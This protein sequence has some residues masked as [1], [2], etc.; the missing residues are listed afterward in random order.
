DRPGRTRTPRASRRARSVGCGPAHRRASAAT[1][2]PP[3]PEPARRRRRRRRSPGR[4]AGAD[5]A[6]SSGSRAQRNRRPCPTAPGYPPDIPEM[7]NT[8]TAGTGRSGPREPV[9]PIRP[10]TG[11]TVVERVRGGLSRGSPSDTVVGRRPDV[12]PRGRGGEHMTTRT[13]RPRRLAGVV[14]AAGLATGAVATAGAPATAYDPDPE[15]TK[16]FR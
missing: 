4:R 12:G 10:G 5:N 11:V 16:T 8:P 6:G 7:S 1:P 15:V 9:G 14:A 13:G 2:V 3:R